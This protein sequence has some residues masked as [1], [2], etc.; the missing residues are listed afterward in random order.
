MQ[1]DDRLIVFGFDGV[2]S[3]KSYEDTVFSP[4]FENVMKTDNQRRD[5]K[6]SSALYFE[7]ERQNPLGDYLPDR[8]DGIARTINTVIRKAGDPEPYK[9]SPS[10]ID[11]LKLL[12]EDKHNKVMI[13]TGNLEEYVGAVLKHNG[14]TEDDLKRI[15]ISDMR[16][17]EGDHYAKVLMAEADKHNIGEIIIY[18]ENKEICD[19]LQ[20]AANARYGAAHVKVIQMEPGEY[21]FDLEFAH[22]GL[23][24]PIHTESAATPKPLPSISKFFTPKTVDEDARFMATKKSFAEELQI[25]TRSLKKD[26]ANAA[27]V[28]MFQ[29]TIDE[30]KVLKDRNAIVNHII[31]MQHQCIGLSYR[32]PLLQNNI[33]S[34]M[35]TTNKFLENAVGKNNSYILIREE[36]YRRINTELRNRFAHKPGVEQEI[37]KASALLYSSS[38][39]NA[40]DFAH[41]L[42]NA[43]KVKPEGLRNPLADMM[44]DTLQKLEVSTKQNKM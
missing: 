20:V 7:L 17:H 8:R 3:K 12:L 31:N 23:R 5:D 43:I 14:L 41:V 27:L 10:A 30:L 38:I 42:E 40:A 33:N 2:L 34:F 26:P 35:T 25:F 28:T 22:E 44:R 15:V 39:K 19:V 18:E 6:L 1:R 36:L 13:I 29:S 32:N 21:S 9:L 24:Q 16:Q 11:Y 4:A 37:K